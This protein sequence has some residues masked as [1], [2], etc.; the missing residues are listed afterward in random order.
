MSNG[1]VYKFGMSDALTRASI[2][3]SQE[4]CK[5]AIKSAVKRQNCDVKA[6]TMIQSS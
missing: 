5:L 4:I 2:L 1:S 6:C 3:I